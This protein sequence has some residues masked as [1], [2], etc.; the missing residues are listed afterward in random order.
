M[1]KYLIKKI[2]FRLRKKNFNKSLQINQGEN[3]LDSL[4]YVIFYSIRFEKT[5]KLKKCE[6]NQLYSDLPNDLFASFNK[7]ELNLR[8][9]L[10][11]QK[12]ERQC[13]FINGVL[14][15]EGYGY[16]LRIYEFETKIIIID[17]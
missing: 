13:F 8:L 17:I 9:D 4:F 7:N 3:T 14:I 15:N 1:K 2:I 6:D 16:F 10:Q 11:Y 5:E 12:F